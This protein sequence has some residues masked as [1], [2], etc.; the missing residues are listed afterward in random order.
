MQRNAGALRVNFHR[1]F[2]HGRKACAMW[3]IAARGPRL[4][5]CLSDRNDS[6]VVIPIT[7]QLFQTFSPGKPE[8][9]NP[10]LEV[11]KSLLFLIKRGARHKVRAEC[12]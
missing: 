11:A 9:R 3:A 1:D 12:R 6:T 5:R 4:P 2:L 8:S 10:D 7:S